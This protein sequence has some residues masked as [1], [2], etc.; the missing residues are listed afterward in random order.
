M[1]ARRGCGRLGTCGS[2]VLGL[3]APLA[4]AQT[5][6]HDRKRGLSMLKN[7]KASCSSATGIHSDGPEFNFVLYGLGITE[8]DVVMT[9][10]GRLENVGVT[11]DETVLPTPEDMAV[12]RDPVLARAAALL[13]VTLDAEAAAKIYDA[14]KAQP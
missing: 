7:A 11:P 2:L 8:A 3:L 14:D 13:G 10:G 1:Q 5:L 9:D 4:L 12:R 6:E